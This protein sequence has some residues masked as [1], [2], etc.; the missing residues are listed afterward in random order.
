MCI[1]KQKKIESVYDNTHVIFRRARTRSMW[2]YI[3]QLE[4]YLPEEI[5]ITLTYIAFVDLFFL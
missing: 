5:K 4:D 1:K 3:T 2:Y